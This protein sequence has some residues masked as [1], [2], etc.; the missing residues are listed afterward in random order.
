M[1][2][3]EIEALK[4]VIL[5]RPYRFVA[6]E[7]INFSTAPNLTNGNVEPRNVVARA[8]CIASKDQYSV[9]PGGL[10]RVA[11]DSETVRVSNQRGGT[12]KDLWILDEILICEKCEQTWRVHRWMEVKTQEYKLLTKY[13]EEE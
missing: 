2:L 8:F 6:Q 5:E 1:T 3:K 9:M 13:V 4:K 10:V 7:H 11:S 12:S